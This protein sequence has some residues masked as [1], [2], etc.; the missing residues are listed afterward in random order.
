MFE[1]ITEEELNKRAMTRVS[2]TP[3]RRTAFGESGM[4][5]EA[6][7]KRFD[8]MPRY[9]AGRI[10]EIF[11]AIADGTFASYLNVD[12]DGK[13]VTLDDLATKLL[14]GEV[15]DIK[16]KSIYKT[17]SLLELANI[18]IRIDNGLNT[19][20]LAERMIMK[21]GESFNT[22]YENA[23]IFVNRDHE[24]IVDKVIER[25]TDVSEEGQ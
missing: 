6:L 10:N 16:I 21:D 15:E 22:F 25:F 9:L 1:Q 20:E 2:S 3:T 19:G 17:V 13:K 4:D 11:E 12:C 18:L 5:A 14:T 24:A 8:S 7:K 23:K